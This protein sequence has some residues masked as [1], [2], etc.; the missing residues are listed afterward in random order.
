MKNISNETVV[1]LLEIQ[2]G[3]LIPLYV[4]K[5]SKLDVKRSA[6]FSNNSSY[7]T[8]K[9]QTLTYFKKVSTLG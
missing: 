6:R 5:I 9:Y 1:K 2:Q 7:S 4:W 3:D 8:S